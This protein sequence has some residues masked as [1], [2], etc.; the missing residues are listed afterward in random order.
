MRA[1]LP[2]N[3][4]TA[5]VSTMIISGPTSSTFSGSGCAGATAAATG[6]TGA[7]GGAAGDCPACPFLLSIR[8]SS[9]CTSLRT[10]RRDITLPAIHPATIPRGKS[11]KPIS[12]LFLKPATIHHPLATALKRHK[13]VLLR[14]T[15][16][17]LG[18]QR[19]ERHRQVPPRLRRLDDVIHETRSARHI[20]IRKRVAVQ[21][22][23][24]LAPPFF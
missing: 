9:R 4:A 18:L 13:P 16:F 1:R 20:R 2:R 14:G 19:F 6:A 23:Q 21:V 22:D 17:A 7:C 3:A 10:R 24:F 11:N 5:A 15:Q 12:S 8:S